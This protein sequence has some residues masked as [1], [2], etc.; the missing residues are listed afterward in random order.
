M[1]TPYAIFIL[2]SLAILTL[3][4]LGL[5]LFKEWEKTKKKTILYWSLGL[6][7]WGV[8]M[9]LDMYPT[10]FNAY[11]VRRFILSLSFGLFFLYGTL[12]LL[13]P[14]KKAKIMCFIYF[15]FINLGDFFFNNDYISLMINLGINSIYVLNPLS[16]VFFF[17]FLTHFQKLRNYEIFWLSIYFAGLFIVTNMLIISISF[18]SVRSTN[19]V[20]SIYY[21]IAMF[22]GFGF[23]A[24]RI[25]ENDLLNKITTPKNYV[26]NQNLL[27]FLKQF[28]HEE[29]KIAIIREL[30]KFKVENITSLDNSQKVEFINAIMDNNLNE[31]SV[32]KRGVYKSKLISILGMDHHIGN[33]QTTIGYN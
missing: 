31:Y 12:L 1:E 29:S 25:S 20:L 3:I 23:E 33:W 2:R 10:D 19:I 11:I 4:Y 21:I 16:M 22:I 28:L 18:N 6:I 17:Y 27:D 24:L 14:E 8:S 13:V 26:I 15:I 30:E 9:I 5:N 32:Q 7:A